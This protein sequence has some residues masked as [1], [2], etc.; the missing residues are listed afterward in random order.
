MLNGIFFNTPL[1]ANWLGHQFS[2]IYKDKIFAPF[3][4]GKKDLT[5]VD[6]GANVGNFSYYASQ[7]AKK[8]YALE[9]SLE[10]FQVLTH[11]LE[12]NKLTDIVV[13]INKA[14]YMQSGRFEFHHN[15]NRT[16]YSLH[17][18]VD[19][20]SSNP[21]LVLAI[22]L[23]DLFKDYN[24]EHVDLMKLDIEGSEHEVV[25]S[26]SFKAVAS[27]INT[28]VIEYHQW[29]GRHPNQLNEALKN[30]GFRVSVMP[31]SADIIVGQR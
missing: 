26:P 13:P 4:N 9:P 7:F 2:E 21:E 23:E 19:D 25:S 24:I 30:N 31:S 22:T 18:A 14:I 20:K 17:T 10:H 12:F 11:M 1:E 6:I 15:A 16:M 28:I 29:S 27:K 8:V 5:I 3:L